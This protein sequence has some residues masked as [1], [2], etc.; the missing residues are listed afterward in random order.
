M[1]KK[2][3]QNKIKNYKEEFNKLLNEDNLEECKNIQ[4]KITSLNSILES[5]EGIEE[6]EAFIEPQ[7]VNKAPIVKVDNKLE[8]INK[9][10]SNFKNPVVTNDVSTRRD[11]LVPKDV[12][13]ELIDIAIRKDNLL[14]LFGVK[15]T[16]ITEGVIPVL[17]LDSYKSIKLAEYTEGTSV[18]TI[19]AP[20][21]KKV[22]WKIKN[23]LGITTES[24]LLLQDSPVNIMEVLTDNLKQAV[25]NT[26]REEA[27]KVIKA[28]SGNSGLTSMAQL[29]KDFL[30]EV[31]QAIKDGGS[32]VMNQNTFATISTLADSVGRFYIT[33]NPA[34]KDGYV[35]F[36]YPVVIV[37]ND[38]TSDNDIYFLNG[39]KAGRFIYNPKNFANITMD[40]S[41]YFSTN[42]V[43]IK[44]EARF[45]FANLST[46][47]GKKFT[48]AIEE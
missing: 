10:I 40:K 21:F 5:G 22:T 14:S 43:G 6:D 42:S 1:K 39:V 29:K 38:E 7:V 11:N 34:N 27:L 18:G 3:I 26:V 23:Y 20:T 8:S 13:R 25:S 41:A 15:E 37:D 45:V 30:K 19:E 9:F 46:T 4:N 33:E 47:A 17:D 31:P 32:F 35:L 48:I 28:L 2:D 12:T 24:L 36:G 16:E 44:T